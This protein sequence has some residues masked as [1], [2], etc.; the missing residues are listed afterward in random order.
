[1]ESAASAMPMIPGGTSAAPPRRARYFL[2]GSVE[3]GAGGSSGS[4]GGAPSVFQQQHQPQ[5]N[6]GQPPSFGQPQPPAFGQPQP[7]YSQLQQAPV[8]AN[9]YGQ[10][11]AP[12]PPSFTAP[13]APP[14]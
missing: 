2:P 5:Q 13:P 8:F 6:Y 11:Q 3:S 9:Q 7:P 12:P 14:S 4:W 10:Q 1:M